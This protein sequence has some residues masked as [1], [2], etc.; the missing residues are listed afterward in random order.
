MKDTDT[1]AEKNAERKIVL[2]LVFPGDPDEW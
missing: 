1:F 2:D